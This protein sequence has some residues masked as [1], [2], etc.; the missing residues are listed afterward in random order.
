MPWPLCAT[1]WQSF[2]VLEKP[3]K[4]AVRKA[5]RMGRVIR[6]KADR[7]SATFFVLYARGTSE[8]PKMGAHED[9]REQPTA[10]AQNLKYFYARTMLADL[11]QWCS[12][13]RS[14]S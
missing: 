9:F 4:A 8:D 12:Q 6:P 5:M 7:R 13:G 1:F 11:L 14:M 3:V 2:D 10:V